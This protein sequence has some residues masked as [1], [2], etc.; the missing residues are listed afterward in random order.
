MI[1]TIGPKPESEWR[2]LP[3]CESGTSHVP[4]EYSVKPES[5]ARKSHASE[6]NTALE[7][8]EGTK[9]TFLSNKQFAERAV[10]QVP[11]ELLHVPLDPHTNSI[12]V[13]MKHVSGNLCSRWTD[14]LNSDGEKPWRK[15]DSE[16][17]DT[18]QSRQEIVAGWEKGWKVLFATLDELSAADLAKV[19]TIRGE[20]H[21]VPLAVQRSLG[22]TCYHVGQIMLVARVHAGST[23]ETITIPRG[24]SEAYNKTHWNQNK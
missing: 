12:A 21:A 8:L 23:W 1:G 5:N 19:V 16:F 20:S 18:F 4:R 10:A 6:A 2:P 22:H 14:F 15:R 11:D 24:G 17:I 9:K 7:F 3:E 13:I